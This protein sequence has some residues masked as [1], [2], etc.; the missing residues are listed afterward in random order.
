MVNAVAWESDLDTSCVGSLDN[1]QELLQNIHDSV[2]QH[3]SYVD[4]AS[5][6]RNLAYVFGPLVS[7]KNES[8]DTRYIE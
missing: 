3:L 6:Q 7:T 1:D 5:F 2:A 8:H 4:A